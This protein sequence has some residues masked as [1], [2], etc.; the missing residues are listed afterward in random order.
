MNKR[1]KNFFVE[2]IPFVVLS[3]C[4]LLL[5]YMIGGKFEEEA[6]AIFSENI[7]IRTISFLL[8]NAIMMASLIPIWKI[9][10]SD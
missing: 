4:V 6:T 2:V 7:A 5:A 3:I 9:N 10:W 8:I 1:L